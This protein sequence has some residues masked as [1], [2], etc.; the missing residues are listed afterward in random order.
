MRRPI[1][2]AA[3]VHK[4][5]LTAPNRDKV[6]DTYLPRIDDNLLQGIPLV[7][8]ELRGHSLC[9]GVGSFS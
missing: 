2:T 1:V 3:R 8:S 5:L 4:S 7:S 6:R 9:L